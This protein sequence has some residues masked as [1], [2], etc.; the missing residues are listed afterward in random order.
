MLS[1]MESNHA[2]RDPDH[3]R[4]ELVAADQARERLSA[5]MRLP[6][7][8]HPLLG[9]AVA[10]Q[11]GTAAIGI[12]RQTAAGMVLLG[13]GLA[14]FLAVAGWAMLAFRRVNGVRVD[15]F[16]SQIVLG[17]GATT[18][19]AYVGAFVVAVWAAFD[20]QWWLVVVASVAGGVGYALGARRWWHAYQADPAAHAAGSSPRVLALL[21][22]SA[23]VVLVVLVVVG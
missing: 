4:A 2:P 1:T 18:S 7:G 8:L 15:G 12:A 16:A 6:E 3:L 11:I 13:T 19:T 9:G 14:V 21:A 20:S 22:L 5:G 17:T 10:L 23:V